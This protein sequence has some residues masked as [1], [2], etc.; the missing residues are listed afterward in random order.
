MGNVT[1]C[2]VDDVRIGMPVEVYFVPAD[3]GV[4]VPFWRPQSVT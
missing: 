4:A 1:G 2:D 3:D